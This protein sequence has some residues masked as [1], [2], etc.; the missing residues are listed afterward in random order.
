MFS[1]NQ[2]KIIQECSGIRT[3]LH[4]FRSLNCP[5][6]MKGALVVLVGACNHVGELPKQIPNWNDSNQYKIN[7]SL[8]MNMN[9]TVF[10]WVYPS[11][12]IPFSAKSYCQVKT[13]GWFGKQESQEVKRTNKK[14]THEIVAIQNWIPNQFW[15]TSEF[16][17][18]Y[19]VLKGKWEEKGRQEKK[20]TSRISNWIMQHIKEI[21][22][23]FKSIFWF[24]SEFN[25]I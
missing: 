23:W 25:C 15:F 6:W 21:Q 4:G 14:G 3:W 16:N 22:N 13:P 8:K 12:G 19:V 18:V 9:I 1:S 24:H 5:R 7:N 11:S 2:H 10:K 17:Y 20:E